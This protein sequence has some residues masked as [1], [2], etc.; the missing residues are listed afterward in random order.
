MSLVSKVLPWTIAV[1]LGFLF[2]YGETVFD[3]DF[4]A[5]ET[6]GDGFL[7][8][9]LG[10]VANTISFG[11]DLLQ[12]ITLGGFSSPLPGVM[13]AILLLAIGLPWFLIVLGLARG[14][15]AS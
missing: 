7:D 3:T 9:L 10:F 14:T 1:Y 12:F 6:S 4:S 8:Q 13:Q 5:S 15:A 11:G 2:I